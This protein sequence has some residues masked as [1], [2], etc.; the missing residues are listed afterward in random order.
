M[1]T[2]FQDSAS[3]V[4]EG[5]VK[6]VGDANI[7]GLSDRSRAAVVTVEAVVRAPQVLVGLEGHDVTIRLADGETVTN[8][9][10]AVFYTNSWIFAE[11]VALW[12]LGHEPAPPAAAVARGAVGR[13]PA[14]AAVH[15]RIRQRVSAAAAV[16]SGKVTAVGLPGPPVAVAAVGPA[17]AATVKISEHDPFWRDA[18]VEV[19]HVHKGAV[20][21]KQVLVRF[22]SST[23]VR[24][25]L[26]P[27]FH[28]GQEGV[29]SLQ[30]VQVSGHPVVGAMAL[31]VGIQPSAMFTCF[32]PADFQPADQRA[33]VA[34]A[35]A[36]ASGAQ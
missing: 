17:P 29:F 22:P 26:A 10:H 23:D 5:A 33:E 21:K 4:F 7:R 16:V 31:A 20:G 35:I 8:G 15:H 28:T 25:H 27:K 12:S 24:W 6:R 9:E 11:N 1:A 34:A 19:Q 14:R 2:S 30:D 3:F 32:N 18:V 36:A 13:D